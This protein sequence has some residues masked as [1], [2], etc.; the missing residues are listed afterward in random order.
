MLCQQL[1]FCL[2]LDYYLHQV[3]LERAVFQCGLKEE[4]ADMTFWWCPVIQR[5]G[6]SFHTNL[7]RY[8]YTILTYDI[9]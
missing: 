8:R 6:I 5:Q 3:T 9:N 7:V 1:M 2:E 4:N